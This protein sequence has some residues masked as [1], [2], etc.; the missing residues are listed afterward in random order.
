MLLQKLLKMNESFDEFK[1]RILKLSDSRKTHSFGTYDVRDI[2][3][4]LKKKDPIIKSLNE[5]TFSG[6]L[7]RIGELQFDDLLD[8]KKVVLPYHMGE[9]MIVSNTSRVYKE[10]GQVKNTL[11]VNWNETVKLWYEHPEYREKKIYV[12]HQPC[13]YFKLVYLPSNRRYKNS[14]VY[15]FQPYR[16]IKKAMKEAVLTH[17][18]TDAYSI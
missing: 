3:R 12:R 4:S 5:A 14:K 8:N 11:K 16:G 9:L 17:K 2:Y 13:K 18:L 15:T 6:I 1:S 7:R 10:D